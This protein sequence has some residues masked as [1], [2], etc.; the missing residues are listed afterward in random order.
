MND[1]IKNIIDNI[2]RGS[3]VSDDAKV[4]GISWQYDAGNDSPATAK[5]WKSEGLSTAVTKAAIGILCALFLIFSL[6][7]FVGSLRVLREDQ[8]SLDMRKP[9]MG[10][11][12]RDFQDQNSGAA[13]HPSAASPGAS[14][15]GAPPAPAP[16]TQDAQS[17]AP[18]PQNARS[19]DPAR[20]PSLQNAPGS[21]PSAP[22]G[23][24]AS[25]LPGRSDG[26][27]ETSPEVGP[28]SGETPR[29]PP[30]PEHLPI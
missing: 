3:T 1:E 10:N 12:A 21:F 29:T 25:P 8:E 27:G 30:D 14:M 16:A 26:R 13:Q 15:P 5:A 22:V 18:A 19:F 11:F 6:A 2:C 4:D 24:P 9:A 23:S 17:F 20:P 7:V 28:E